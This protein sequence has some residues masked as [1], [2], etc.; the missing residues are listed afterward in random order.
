LA[1]APVA[2]LEADRI[3]SDRDEATLGQ[4]DGVRLIAVSTKSADLTLAEVEL[5][6]V[7]VMAEDER[8]RP[9]D[10]AGNADEGLCSAAGNVI[11][12]V[13]TGVAVA[14]GLFLDTRVQRSWFVNG[15]EGLPERR[16][17]QDARG[18]AR[19]IPTSTCC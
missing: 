16:S 13:A 9:A 10:T 6:R 18:H 7:L 15:P 4:L 12:D 19:I 8:R 2:V 14:W 5:V 11:G 17:C 1:L 3:R